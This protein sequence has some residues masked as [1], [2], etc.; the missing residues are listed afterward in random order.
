MHQTI[1]SFWYVNQGERLLLRT[2]ARLLLRHG[3][4]GKS[5]PKVMIL[6][7]N[8]RWLVISNMSLS[9]FMHSTN[10]ECLLGLA[11]CCV[12]RWVLRWCAACMVISAFWQCNPLVV[13]LTYTDWETPQLFCVPSS[14]ETGQTQKGV[15]NQKHHPYEWWVTCWQMSS[16][17]LCSFFLVTIQKFSGEILVGPSWVICLSPRTITGAGMVEPCKGWLPF[18]PHGS[19]GRGR[20]PLKEEGHI[21]P[22]GKEVLDK[23]HKKYLMEGWAHG[24]VHALIGRRNLS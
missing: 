1:S 16:K 20:G 21:F 6:L 24:C 17:R 15:K 5:F 22:A 11:P 18:G 13:E 7:K 12:L 4:A 23:P 8:V 14:E 2:L 19:W 9:T 10:T 3:P